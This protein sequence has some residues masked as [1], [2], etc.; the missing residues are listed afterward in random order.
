MKRKI[1]VTAAVC[2][3]SA[4]CVFGVTACSKD[5]GDSGSGHPDVGPSIEVADEAAWK[6]AWNKTVTATN[7]T[8]VWLDKITDGIGMEA[9]TMKAYFWGDEKFLETKNAYSG[10]RDERYE[11]YEYYVVKEN[12][13]SYYANEEDGSW[14]V[15][16]GDYFMG[17][18]STAIF[19]D[20]RFNGGENIANL[21]SEFTY[22]SDK[23]TASLTYEGL[24]ASVTVKINQDGYVSY[25]NCT[26][27]DTESG[28]YKY[29]SE[30]TFYNFGT[31]SYN[32]PAAAKQAVEDYKAANN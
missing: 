14:S 29:T 27:D 4:A 3:L 24:T 18:I 31:T 19:F 5:S 22:G 2:A 7:F 6:A 11:R 17:E 32:V 12:E 28:Y 9:T 21:F 10:G 30:Y 16:V 8:Y 13:T 20:D 1:L 25:F 23:Y 15:G 26:I